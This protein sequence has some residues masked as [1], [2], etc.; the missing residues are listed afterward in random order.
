[1]RPQEEEQQQQRL[2]RNFWQAQADELWVCLEYKPTLLRVWSL[3]CCTGRLWDSEDHQPHGETHTHAHIHT[4][5][6]SHMLRIIVR[7]WRFSAVST[8]FGIWWVNLRLKDGD[9]MCVSMCSTV[10][11]CPWLFIEC[12]SLRY[13]LCFFGV[14][15]FLYCMYTTFF[16]L[17]DP[18]YLKFLLLQQGSTYFFSLLC[19]SFGVCDVLGG[20][21]DPIFTRP[22]QLLCLEVDLR[23]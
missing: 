21:G 1:M 3:R 18:W 17:T 15:I 5:T 11:L 20:D 8:T 14:S 19:C 16:I 6:R 12:N 23:T 22:P 7:K 4:H 2:W 9:R 13:C 10:S